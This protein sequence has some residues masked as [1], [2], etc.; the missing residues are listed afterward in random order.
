MGW[1]AHSSAEMDYSKPFSRIRDKQIRRY[2]KKASDFVKAKTGTVDCL[3]ETGSLDCD[4]CA[5]MLEAATGQTCWMD[6]WSEADVQAIRE[7]AC[8]DNISITKD[9]EWAFWSARKFLETCANLG[10]SINFSW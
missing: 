10:L 8:W 1:D 9:D 5:K 4:Q 7:T 3:L 2:F 6:G